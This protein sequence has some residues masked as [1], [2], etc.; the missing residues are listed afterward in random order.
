MAT[1]NITS[2]PST[3][4]RLSFTVSPKAVPH[5]TEPN[6]GFQNHTEP[7]ADFQNQ[8][9]DP[10]EEYLGSF[11]PDLQ[12]ILINTNGTRR[13]QD[14]KNTI[15]S[16]II[17]KKTGRYL[18]E[19]GGFIWHMIRLSTAAGRGPLTSS[20]DRDAIML[21]AYAME[22][23]VTIETKDLETIHS[24]LKRAD[25]PQKAKQHMEKVLKISKDNGVGSD[26]NRQDSGKYVSLPV[27]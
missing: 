2:L 16:P 13:W 5:G 24:A 10:D 27:I 21:G 23:G 9:E 11:N 25:F 3:E 26:C 7:D 22:L 14:L 4:I 12:A 15:N 20:A 19:H 17:R 18:N 1:L 8:S 6:A